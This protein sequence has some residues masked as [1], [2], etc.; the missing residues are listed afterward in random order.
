M[1]T[2]AP[3]YD[4]VGQKK[5][6]GRKARGKAL[7]LLDRLVEHSDALLA[8]AEFDAVPSSNNQAERGIR[9]VKTKQK[10][11]GCFR[12]EMA[13]SLLQFATFEPGSPFQTARFLSQN[14]VKCNKDRYS[15]DAF[16]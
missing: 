3:V 12:T 8:F 5:K 14:E 9:P 7:S 16:P 15:P 2:S 10:V 6:R 13:T 11:A 4:E 1:V